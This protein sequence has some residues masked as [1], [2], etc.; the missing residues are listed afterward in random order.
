MKLVRLNIQ[1][2]EGGYVLDCVTKD[3]V[4]TYNTCI[5]CATRPQLLE[6]VKELVERED[7]PEPVDTE[8]VK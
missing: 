8:E 6:K 4:T 2:A 1:V 3:K 5:I 7:E